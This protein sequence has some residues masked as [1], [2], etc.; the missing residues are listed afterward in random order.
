MI[1]NITIVTLLAVIAV[2][3][4]MAVSG[5][6][7]Q[8][9]IAVDIAVWEDKETGNFYASTRPQGG[10]WQ[11][12]RRDDPLDMRFTQ[13]QRYWR[14]NI[15]KI[16]APFTIDWEAL[17]NAWKIGNPPWS[18][19]AICTL[20]EGRTGSGGGYDTPEEARDAG[21]AWVRD[22]CINTTTG[23]EPIEPSEVI[24]TPASR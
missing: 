3:G 20:P 17:A 4:V 21:W 16:V 7:N 1:K 14:S 15:I 12:Q 13:T 11:T 18:W 9:E 24:V 2:G 5:Q 22:N 6:G 19:E 10:E 8:A 23:P